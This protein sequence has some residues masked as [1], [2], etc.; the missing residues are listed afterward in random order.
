MAV[1]IERSL[2]KL[3]RKISGGE[4]AVRTVENLVQYIAD[5]YQQSSGGSGRK[6]DP[7]VGINSIVGTIDSSN[8]MTL[9]FTM[10][11]GSSQKVEGRINHVK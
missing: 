5:H 8:K 3:A 2:A 10:S 1:S 4:P 7:G 11:D 6:G 9:T